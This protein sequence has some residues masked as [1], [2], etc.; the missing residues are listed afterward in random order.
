[1]QNRWASNNIQI[2]RF[3]TFGAKTTIKEKK[4]FVYNIGPKA[5]NSSLKSKLLT[6]KP[7]STVWT[8]NRWLEAL[9]FEKLTSDK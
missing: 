3:K 6:R 4:S 9:R 2:Q 5:F 7:Q 1:M 8:I